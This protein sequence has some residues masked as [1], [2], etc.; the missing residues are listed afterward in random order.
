MA[1]RL[2]IA[3]HSRPREPVRDRRVKIA[4]HGFL[5][6]QQMP[7]FFAYNHASLRGH[8]PDDKTDFPLLAS[9]L[10]PG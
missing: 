8:E 7:G 4:V 9:G 1:D 5:A 10:V 6:R 2:H 3:S